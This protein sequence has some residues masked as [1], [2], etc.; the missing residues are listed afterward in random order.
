MA[1]P[2]SQSTI[3]WEPP[4][5][6]WK[7]NLRLRI[8]QS[9]APQ[10]AEAKRAHA[11][12][13]A[14]V[15]EEDFVTRTALNAQHEEVMDAIRRKA[16]DEFDHH[17][18]GEILQRR[19]VADHKLDSAEW[20]MLQRYQQTLFDHVAKGSPDRERARTASNEPCPG[21]GLGAVSM[22]RTSSAG[23]SAAGSAPREPAAGVLLRPMAAEA[24]EPGR[25]RNNSVAST[26][27]LENH[28]WS[29]TR[30]RAGS[31]SAG[32]GPSGAIRIPEGPLER[33]RWTPLTPPDEPVPRASRASPAST[34][35]SDAIVP[36]RSKTR[37][38]SRGKGWRSSLSPGP[39]PRTQASRTMANAL[40]DVNFIVPSPGCA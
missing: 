6:K 18:Q 3:P 21:S 33:E 35:D 24:P 10:V 17:L 26:S 11:S 25:R 2:S 15:E 1:S 5:E 36:R 37:I 40:V 4:D 8:Q 38:T 20:A 16:Q 7:R 28:L 39:E 30:K 27:S 22:V 23:T 29:T 19:Y 31:S 14:D 34:P 13:L 32:S 12:A 9:L